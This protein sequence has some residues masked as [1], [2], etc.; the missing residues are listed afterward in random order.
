MQCDYYTGWFSV[1]VIADGMYCCPDVIT[2]VP[3]VIPNITPSVLVVP[4]LKITHVAVPPANAVIGA[5]AAF[6]VTL[7]PLT[8]VK[9]AAVRPDLTTRAVPPALIAAALA[10]LVVC[11]V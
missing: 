3:V 6:A 8:T 11:V 10:G 1:Q 5:T 7:T 4:V 9:S 2:V